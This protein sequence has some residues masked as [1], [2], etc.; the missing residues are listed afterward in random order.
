MSI[1]SEIN[2]HAKNENYVSEISFGR[3]FLAFDIRP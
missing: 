1:L 2:L 3:Q